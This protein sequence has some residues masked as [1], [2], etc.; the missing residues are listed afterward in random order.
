MND[1]TLIQLACQGDVDAVKQFVTVYSDALVR[2]AYIF[3]KDSTLAEDIA[4]ETIATVLFKQKSKVNC[5]AYLYKIARNKCIDAIRKR[6][7][8]VPIEDIENVLYA[9]S[10]ED[11]FIKYERKSLIYKCIQKLPIQYKDIVYLHYLNDVSVEELCFI[12]KKNKKQVYN[13]IARSKDSLKKILIE[14]GI[15]DE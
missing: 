5:E 6:K 1:S 2:F 8:V 11:V 13:L 14:E 12:L 9:D 3:V 10:T 7:R 15:Y 4:S